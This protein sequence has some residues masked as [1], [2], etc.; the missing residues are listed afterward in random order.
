M[1]FDRQIVIN[2]ALGEV[3][4]LEKASNSQLDS[5]TANAGYGNWTKYARDLDRITGFY[6]G[7]KNGFAYCDIFTDWCFVTA[8]G[9]ENA[10]KLLCQPDNSAGAGCT[11][12]AQ[13]YKKK[14]QFHK[15]NPQPGDQIFFGNASEC[16]HT[17]IVT[18]VDKS[19]VYTVEGNT[20]GASGVIA[21]GGG[22]REKSYPLT[23]N[24]IHGYGRPNYDDDYK[25]P[26]TSSTSSATITETTNTNGSSGGL[27]DT[28]AEV[29]YWLNKAFKS[30]LTV[31]GLYGSLT[32]AALTKALQTALGVES[33]GIYGKITNAAVKVLRQGDEGTLV[34]ILQA[35]LVCNGYKSA[36]VD[37]E[38]GSGTYNALIAYQRRMG[39]L[40]DGEAGQETFRSLCK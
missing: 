26:S 9:V 18:A 29:Q 19:K 39:L 40:V 22:V 12:S 36:Y 2:I 37:G 25:A 33:D 15:K 11:Y 24:Q 35:F 4:Y 7:K 28:V 5:K 23:Y 16:T 6:N 32:K 20:S 31:D 13:Y 17:G 34:K 3:G 27:I 10:K 14:G 30:G 38:F 1:S 21:N 8:Y